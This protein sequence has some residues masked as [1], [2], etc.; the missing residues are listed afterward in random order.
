MRANNRKSIKNNDCIC[1][2]NLNMRFYVRYCIAAQGSQGQALVI[3]Y[4]L[5][6]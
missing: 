5:P 6:S 4:Q 2:L 1:I 3:E